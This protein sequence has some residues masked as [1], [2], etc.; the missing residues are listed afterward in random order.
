MT[1]NRCYCGWLIRSNPGF[2]LIIRARYRRIDYF[3]LSFILKQPQ[4]NRWLLPSQTRKRQINPQI[5]SW[6]SDEGSLTQRLKQHCPGRFAVHVLAEEWGRPDPAEARLLGI[7]HTQ[8]VLL[9]QVH[10][11]CADQLCVYARSVI[12][13]TTLK[14]RHRRLRYLGNRPLGEYLFSSPTLRRQRVEWGCLTPGTSLYRV[15]IAGQVNAG[16]L[17]WGRRSLFVI[18]GKSLLVSEFF[19]PVLFA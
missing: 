17:I 13:L 5:L 2:G 19:L 10:L 11:T 7:P 9:R 4:S 12:P 3:Y 15:A 6:L 16:E 1:R 14:G 8:H 18:D